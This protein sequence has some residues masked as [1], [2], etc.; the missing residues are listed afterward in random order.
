[1]G[2]KPK[3]K[4]TITKF[5]RLPSEKQEQKYRDVVA[6]YRKGKTTEQVY[7]FLEET[8]GVKR[9]TATSL[10][11]Q[12]MAWVHKA[13][14]EKVG[15]YLLENAR[16]MQQIR[17][18]DVYNRCIESR[19]YKEA[20]NALRELNKIMGLYKDVTV[21]NNTVVNA[22]DAPT[23]IS[24]RFGTGGDTQML[25]EPIAQETRVENNAEVSVMEDES[26]NL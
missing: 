24:F 10:V 18:E 6:Q 15:G 4:Q 13:Q 22:G 7:E 11:K 23:T 16:C 8:Y 14:A 3:E 26:D 19:N 20:I 12:T 21:N 25:V 17:L 5:P 9:A 2:R 1:M